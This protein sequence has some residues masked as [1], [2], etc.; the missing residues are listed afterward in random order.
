MCSV[1][2]ECLNPRGSFDDAVFF[3]FLIVNNGKSNRSLSR[4]FG[5]AFGPKAYLD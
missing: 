5:Y 3:S 4:K 2:N 1:M